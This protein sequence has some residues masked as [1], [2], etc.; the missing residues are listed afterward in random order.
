M[1]TSL[2]NEETSVRRGRE[3][4]AGVGDEPVGTQ[5]LSH[6]AHAREPVCVSRDLRRDCV[7]QRSPTEQFTTGRSALFNLGGVTILLL[8]VIDGWRLEISASVVT[9]LQLPLLG[10]IVLG[11]GPTAAAAR[12]YV[13]GGV[14]DQ[15]LVNTSFARS[16]FNQAGARAT[17]VAADLF[18]RYA[19]VYRYAASS[20]RARADHHGL[21]FPAGDLWSDAVVHEPDEGLLDS[22]AEPEHGVWSVHQSPPLCRL[23]GTDDRV[24]VGI[25]VCRRGRKREADDLLCSLPD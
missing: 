10:A 3:R 5:R 15:W 7:F 20:A 14:S 8:W 22:R 17:G 19:C 21:W 12:S 18:R 25:A 9:L 13:R 6:P 1:T 2:S 11:L 4:A 24:A 16:E 23:H